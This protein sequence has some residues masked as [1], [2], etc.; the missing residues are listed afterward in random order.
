MKTFN[1]LLSLCAVVCIVAAC[2]SPT[3]LYNSGNYYQATTAAISKLRSSPEKTENQDI[4]MQAYPQ[5]VKMALREI[6]NASQSNS[7]TKYDVMINQYEQLNRLANEI[8]ACPKA[9]ELIPSPHEFHAELQ[10]TKDIAAEHYYQQGINALSARTVEQARL[11]YQYFL[12]ANNYKNGYRDV[13]SKIDEALFAA[14]LHVVVEAPQTP[15]R[16]QVSA[17]FFYSNLVTEMNKTNQKK[18]V[19]FYTPSEAQDVGMNNPQQYVVLDFIDFTVG[20]IRESSNSQ[21]IK[22]DSVVVSTVEVDGKKYPAYATVKANLTTNRREIISGGNLHVRIIDAA[23]NRVIEQRTFE[24]SYVW[25][26]V[27]ANY[28]GDDRALSAEQKKLT[29]QQ[30]TLPPPNQ[31]L[32]IEFTKPIYSQVVSYIRYV[33]RNYQ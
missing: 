31:D 22:R 18:F 23:S 9:N 13:I 21:E 10:Q 33:Y 16:F 20:N 5:A 24:G 12:Q 7:V 27:W 26:S 15:A 28:T 25:T 1:R 3:K 29:T 2:T 11:A 19:L 6:N 30:A 8:Y 17:D 14:T 4:L 32:F